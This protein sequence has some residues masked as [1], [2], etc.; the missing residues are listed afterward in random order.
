MP[1]FILSHNKVQNAIETITEQK[2][3][4]YRIST[5]DNQNVF[6]YLYIIYFIVLYINATSNLDHIPTFDCKPKPSI[7]NKIENTSLT[8]KILTKTQYNLV[9]VHIEVFLQNLIDLLF[10][11][12]QIVNFYTP[13]TRIIRHNDSFSDTITRTNWF[14]YFKNFITSKDFS[15]FLETGNLSNFKILK[16]KLKNKKIRF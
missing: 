2:T 13:Y 5:K 3:S 11:E 10:D 12:N 1:F 9:V 8:S 16:V 7:S 6:K 14:D 4:Y 15:I